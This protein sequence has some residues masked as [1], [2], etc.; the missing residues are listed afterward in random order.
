MKNIFFAILTITALLFTGC[1]SLPSENID[2]SAVMEHEFPADARQVL[3]VT[4]P[5]ALGS[6]VD[7]SL[8]GTPP[9]PLRGES[10][11]KVSRKGMRLEGAWYVLW[12]Q[13]DKLCLRLRPNEGKARAAYI[14]LTGTGKSS[15]RFSFMLR[16]EGKR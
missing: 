9:W 12:W 5:A 13:G 6:T 2:Y 7:P 4:T 16:Q 3:I 10:G 14:D 15:M 11:D 8:T 1:R